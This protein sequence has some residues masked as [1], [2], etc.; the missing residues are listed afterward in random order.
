[1]LAGR[2]RASLQ[3]GGVGLLLRKAANQTRTRLTIIPASRSLHR[4]VQ[5]ASDIERAVDLAFDFSYDRLSVS[6]Q[7][8]RSEITALLRYLQ[9][10][11]PRTV[12]EIGTASGGTL[13]LLASVAAD[14]AT[15]VTLDLPRHFSRE[16]LHRAVARSRQVIHTVR[17]DS[18]APETKALVQELIG[19]SP[20]DFLFIDGDHSYRGVKADY[21]DYAP[22]VAPGGA[23]AFHDIVPGPEEFVG[24]VPAF[25]QEL[26]RGRNTH[27]F[28]E[29][30]DQG[31]LGIGLI[32]T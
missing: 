18:H 4:Q 15:L 25:W 11:P 9:Q 24:G 8:K 29:N 22:L 10:R 13:L 28:V 32:E 14:D 7:Q 1:M 2:I 20:I 31:G 27:E 23:I 30:W 21:E 16:R 26:E 6:P 5:E 17:G 19:G 12:V 3:E